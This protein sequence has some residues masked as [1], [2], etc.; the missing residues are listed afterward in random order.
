VTA[1]QRVEKRRW[2][3]A[4]EELGGGKVAPTR[5][6]RCAR[7]SLRRLRPSVGG[8]GGLGGGG[9]GGGGSCPGVQGS[10]VRQ[11]IGGSAPPPRQPPGAIGLPLPG[12]AIMAVNIRDGQNRR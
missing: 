6:G 3:Q 7:H 8:G 4:L 5:A 9:G 1:S 2:R 12:T 11:L 10:C